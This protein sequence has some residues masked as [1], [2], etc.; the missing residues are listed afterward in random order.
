MVV[1]VAKQKSAAH[2]FVLQ[3]NKVR[4]VA[5]CSAEEAL[6]G[7]IVEEPLN[8]VFGGGQVRRSPSLLLWLV[9]GLLLLQP[10]NGLLSITVLQQC[11]RLG[12]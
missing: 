4:W 10:A 12:Q 7:G 6:N 5:W 9:A 3:K 11:Q 8:K 1:A 2:N